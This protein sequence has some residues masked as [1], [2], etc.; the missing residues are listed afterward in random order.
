MAPDQLVAWKVPLPIAVPI[1][2]LI[3]M[4]WP[5]TVTSM[6]M[7]VQALGEK[8]AGQVIGAPVT[9]E[10]NGV[11]RHATCIPWR[12]ASVMLVLPLEKVTALELPDAANW[13]EN[14]S[15]PKCTR[16]VAEPVKLLWRMASEDDP[17]S[18]VTVRTNSD[19]GCDVDCAVLIES[20]PPR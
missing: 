15:K 4:A 8:V 19:C 16:D 6:S 3:P 7:C 2:I 10:P 13:L 20:W 12:K 14:T 1:A 9:P 18:V 17:E 5:E 11:R